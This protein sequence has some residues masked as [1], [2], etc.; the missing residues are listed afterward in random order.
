MVYMSMHDPC[1]QATVPLPL[2]HAAPVLKLVSPTSAAHKGSSAEHGQEGSA[3]M[4]MRSADEINDHSGVGKDEGGGG[5]YNADLE[6]GAIAIPGS[7]LSLMQPKLGSGWLSG[8]AGSL[9]D[10][11][12]PRK[13]QLLE[14]RRSFGVK[15]SRGR[16]RLLAYARVSLYMMEYHWH[17]MEYHCI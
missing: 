12:T 13:R 11:S 2:R 16:P 15:R 5:G 9:A 4:A 17:M 14:V 8:A 1:M 6:D 10:L 3:S 7:S